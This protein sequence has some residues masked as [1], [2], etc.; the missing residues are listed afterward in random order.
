[1]EKQTGKKGDDCSL[2]HQENASIIGLAYAIV[3]L[4]AWLHKRINID[5]C[6]YYSLDN[7][8]DCIFNSFQLVNLYTSV[9]T[10]VKSQFILRY[11]R[12]FLIHIIV[13]YL[14]YIE[15]QVTVKGKNI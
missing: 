15:Q 1:M 8:V 9:Q 14:L 13:Q 2:Q 11:G 3:E 10:E 6:I 12:P 7:I 4:L 5:A